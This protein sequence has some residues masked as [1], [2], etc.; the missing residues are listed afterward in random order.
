MQNKF[1]NL[2]GNLKATRF[3]K[4]QNKAKAYLQ[5]SSIFNVN[6]MLLLPIYH[7]RFGTYLAQSINSQVVLF[8]RWHFPVFLLL[9]N[10]FWNGKILSLLYDL[11]LK[12]KKW[13]ITVRF[14]LNSAKFY[15]FTYF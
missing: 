15:F 2:R 13:F 3:G 7:K 4:Q 1:E 5:I 9:S 12:K 8:Y 14:V 6:R 10:L 11:L